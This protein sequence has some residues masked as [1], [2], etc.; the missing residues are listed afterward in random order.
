MFTKL[1]V[2]PDDLSQLRVQIVVILLLAFA[3]FYLQARAAAIDRLV[4][5]GLLEMPVATSDFG[6][7]D[8]L[9]SGATSDIE[10]HLEELR[11]ELS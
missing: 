10:R 1:L 4:D 6:D 2:N 11:R 7:D 3:N 9:P 8:L 5:D